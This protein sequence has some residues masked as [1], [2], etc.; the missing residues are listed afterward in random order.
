MG[1]MARGKEGAR[2]VRFRSPFA[3]FR[4]SRCQIYSFHS[5]P[6]CFPLRSVRS[7]F[8]MYVTRHV[9]KILIHNCFGKRLIQIGEMAPNPF[10]LIL[11]PQFVRCI[12]SARKEWTERKYF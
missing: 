3:L 2:R 11:P 5:Y 1:H 12:R 10:I 7:E 4:L 6:E 8:R 9:S